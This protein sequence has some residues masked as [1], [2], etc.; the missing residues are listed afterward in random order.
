MNTNMKISRKINGC[1]KLIGMKKKKISKEDIENAA[2]EVGLSYSAM[3]IA[4][5]NFQ[6]SGGKYVDR[7][8]TTGSG[9]IKITPKTICNNWSRAVSPETAGDILREYMM[10]NISSRA[11]C[12]KHNISVTQFYSWISE[13]NISGTILGK[14]VLNPKK[15]AKIEVKDVIWMRKNPKTTRKSIVNL[16]ECEK[17]A[18][19][20][21]ADILM[22]YLPKKKKVKEV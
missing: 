22:M 2:K 15:Y 5:N 14:K 21:V 3:A 7:R 1:N 18:Y 4:W 10:T 9:S 6:Q 19:E 13:L 20:R 8:N 16:T 17:M 11:I 12:N